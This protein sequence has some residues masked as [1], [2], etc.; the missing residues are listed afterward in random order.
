MRARAPPRV[1]TGPIGSL[2]HSLSVHRVMLRDQV[3]TKAF[4]EALMGTVHR[5]TSSLT[6]VPI[7]EFFPFRCSS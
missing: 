2:Y 4:R 6:S 3:R 1:S 7:R 5:A